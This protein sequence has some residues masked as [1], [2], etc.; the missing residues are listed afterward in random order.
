[1]ILVRQKHLAM[2]RTFTHTILT[3][4]CLLCGLHGV[5]QQL[6]GN[7]WIDYD[8]PYL[9]IPVVETG[10]YKITAREIAR[11][12]IPLDSMLV[13]DIQMFGHGRE[14]PIEVHG[15]ADGKLG[16][17]GYI[18]FSGERNDG[19]AD[20]ALYISP[21]AMPHS[22]YSLYSDTTAYFLAWRND[23][24]PRQRTHFPNPGTIVDTLH[25]EGLLQVFTSH[26]LP[27]RF[28]PKES[29]YNTGSLLTAYD[30]G[31][32]WTGPEIAENT[33]FEIV[34]K[35]I[36][37]VRERLQDIECEVM[38]AGWSQGMHS[39][40]LWSGQSGKLKRRLMDI[41]IQD[42]GS[43][44]INVKLQSGDFDAAGQLTLTLMPAGTG[45]N[46]SVSYARMRYPQAGERVVR[47]PMQSARP[48]LVRFTRIDPKTEYLIV[49]HP[50]MHAPVGGLDAVA[51]YA[52]YRA[53]QKGGNYKVAILNSFE[54]YD[55]FN[56]G[57]PG[58]KGIS[59]VIHWLHGQGH[60][61][62][63]LLAGRSIDPQKARKMKDSWQTDMVPNA[64]WPGSDIALVTYKSDYKP[65][66]PIGRINALNS[67]QLLDYLRKVQAM[68]AEPASAGWRK[69]ILH[70]SGGR[71]RDEL[72]TFRSYINSFEKKLE[73]SALAP[74]ITNISKLTDNAVEPVGIDRQMNDGVALITIFGHSS[75]DVT[76]IDIGHASDPA[77]NYHNHPR[78]PAVIVN[79]CAS[80][81][82]F[83]STH[84]LSSDWIFAPESGAVLFLAHT[85]N[86]PS[87][88]LKRYTDLFY[89]V[90]ADSAF[91]AEPFGTI[92]Q[93]AIRRNL[94]RNPGILDSITVQQMTLHG[95]PAIRIFPEPFHPYPADS[96]AHNQPPVVIVTVDGRQLAQGDVVSLN[97]IVNLRIFDDKLPETSNDTT[98]VAVWLKMQCTGCPDMRVSM[99]KAVGKNAAGRFYEISL[100]LS[101]NTGKYTLTVQCRD[102]DGHSALPY[103]ISFEVPASGKP[104]RA[105]VGPNPS[106]RWFRFTVYNESLIK[107][108]LKL[109]IINASGTTV[110]LQV[111]TCNTGRND[112]FWIP[113][114]L[115]PG[116]PA[117]PATG[118]PAGVY[119]YNISTLEVAHSPA[120]LFEGSRGH[121]LYTP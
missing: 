91:T 10:I 61:K 68:E 54:L 111:L 53:S 15:N 37:L 49:T 28:F 92:Q 25:L 97:P 87:T 62:F 40:T 63:V 71:S 21:A 13:S 100:P 45:G 59:N 5:A 82:I 107:R 32:G 79:G 105:V 58:P 14:L 34:F 3:I 109:N 38:I 57:Q 112:W 17:D 18:M 22:Y 52:R 51:E 95:D 48:R 89:E 26:Y 42:R 29:D 119:H 81:S 77:R 99:Q 65:I 73:G 118:L 72:S 44:L 12:G 4:L 83:Y 33:S 116:L 96:T 101:L 6:Y 93:E 108:D 120:F 103:Q 11:E 113:V 55:Q 69:R 50:L 84:T 90:L 19:K 23:G 78:Y 75:I 74:Q 115:S 70:L 88:A 67:Q 117:G 98:M 9:R 60:L 20:T 86:G 2:T 31:E 80:G 64:G 30:K 24:K 41:N 7:E 121:L 85:F 43:Q 46:A 47:E 8:R 27:G 36:N 66:V 110:F 106:G 16:V 114:I 76:D 35:T 104:L 39:F 102:E 94:A 56:A 1:M